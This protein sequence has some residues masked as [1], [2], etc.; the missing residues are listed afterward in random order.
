MFLHEFA[1]TGMEP[2]TRRYFYQDPEK[3]RGPENSSFSILL[4]V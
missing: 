1:E 4:I 3:Q 2:E